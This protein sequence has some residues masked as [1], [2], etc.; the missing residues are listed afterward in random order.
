M[1]SSMITCQ[2]EEARP[3]VA[4]EAPPQMLRPAVDTE[5]DGI[6]RSDRL[7]G[8]PAILSDHVEE[9]RA[10]LVVGKEPVQVASDR[11]ALAPAHLGAGAL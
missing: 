3:G 6:G 1:S 7:K 2:G 4:A 5:I 10:P 8:T 11:A 9:R